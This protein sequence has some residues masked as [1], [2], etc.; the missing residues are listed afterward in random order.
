MAVGFIRA[1][2][3]PDPRSRLKLAPMRGVL[4]PRP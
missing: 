2:S 1:T 4:R 3:D